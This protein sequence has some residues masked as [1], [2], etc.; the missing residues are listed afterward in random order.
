[1]W[2]STGPDS[3]RNAP[4]GAVPDFDNPEDVYWTLNV[5]LTSI[6]IVFTTAF[7]AVR[8]YVKRTINRKILTEDWVC[9]VAYLTITTYC[10]TV[11]MKSVAHYGAGYHAWEI[12][13]AEYYN[14]LKWFYG[15]T[16][17]YCPS[18]FFTKATILLLMAR[19]FAGERRVS[20]GIRIFIWFL[21]VAYIPIEIVRIAS[22]FP[23]RSLWDPSVENARCLN[24]RRI[25]F[26]SLALS[27]ITDIAIL[28]I[29]IPLTWTL[30]MPK[31]KKVKIVLLL[32]AGGVA[33]TLT[34]LRTYKVAQ[35]LDSEDITVDYTPIAILI[36]LEL[37]IGFV[38]ACLPSL[39][40]LIE[41]SIRKRRREQANPQ[42]PRERH[43]QSSTVKRH[44]RWV[45]SST[46]P[47]APPASHQS[48]EN[49]HAERMTDLDVEM[50]MLTGQP[51]RLQTGRCE[52]VDSL[53]CRPLEHR[54]NSGDG[55]REGWLSGD[56]ENSDEC[57][58]P[59]YMMKMV[60]SSKL[61]AEQGAKES[62]CPVWDGPR[63]PLS[64]QRSWQPSV[65][66]E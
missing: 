20:K 50:A 18:A 12:P 24:Q 49:R 21:L 38:C 37:S 29:P 11:L 66:K 57:Q 47:S 15:S 28:I 35:F 51:L 48:T 45:S 4:P 33:T 25:F 34:I 32:G 27:I 43:V 16:V 63:D 30:R 7:F 55:R 26:S 3:N 56:R 9:A 39:N 8:I 10:T 36:V 62:W 61:Q 60:E 23:I 46:T 64:S 22:C 1:M 13:K 2:N 59:E 58:S 54:L 53:A 14:W 52:S 40:L 65:R 42:W 41:H 6:C 44:F 17:V 5:V 19:V 31:R